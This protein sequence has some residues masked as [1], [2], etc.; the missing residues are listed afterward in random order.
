MIPV[1]EQYKAKETDIRPGQME[2]DGAQKW[3][4]WAMRA[5]EAERRWEGVGVGREREGSGVSLLGPKKKPIGTLRRPRRGLSHQRCFSLRSQAPP[6][7][8]P[9]E[10]MGEGVRQG[11]LGNRA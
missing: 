3:P 10:R 2:V 6:I 8:K 11:I 1:R 9:G 5:G 4:E 7:S